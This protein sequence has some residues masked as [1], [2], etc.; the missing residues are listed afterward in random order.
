MSWT[1]FYRDHSLD[2]RSARNAAA[3]P[4]VRR[5]GGTSSGAHRVRHL[6]HAFAHTSRARQG[7]AESA[8]GHTAVSRSDRR[9]SRSWRPASPLRPRRGVTAISAYG[10]PTLPRH[11][12]IQIEVRSGDALEWWF[13][14]P[15]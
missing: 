8:P 2:F 5:L 6:L 4:K 15:R 12:P 11:T 10:E 13:A 1:D 14:F 3:D 9:D 7:H